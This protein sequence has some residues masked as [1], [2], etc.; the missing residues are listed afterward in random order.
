MTP[1]LK[2]LALAA[3][4]QYIQFLL[5]GI[6]LNIQ[7]GVQATA[8]PRDG[9]LKVMGVAGRLYRAFNNHFEALILFTIAVVVVTLSDQSTPYTAA[10]AWA[11]LISRILYIPAYISGI[12]FLRTAV[13]TV[14]F[15]ATLA[16]ILSVLI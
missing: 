16:M 10:C 11:Y 8:G 5:M 12:P 2:V 7:L 6:P 13:F 14:G 4:L 15:G 1:E 3:I 9:G